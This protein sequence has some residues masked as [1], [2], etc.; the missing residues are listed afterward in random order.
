MHT[1]KEASRL[2]GLSTAAIKKRI[3]TGKLNA[4]KVKTPQG[5]ITWHIELPNLNT[6][7]QLVQQWVEDMKTGKEYPKPFSPKTIA[8]RLWYMGDLWKYSQEDPS[9]QALHQGTLKKALDALNTHDKCRFSTKEGILKAY[10]AF[11]SWL[12]L[13]GYAQEKHLAGL[14]NLKPK[15]F[16]PPRR[17]KLQAQQVHDLLQK[18]EHYPTTPYHK[19]RLKLLLKLILLSGLRIAE[20]LHLKLEDIRFDAQELH[21]LGK[22]NK[23]R[24]T[25]LPAP[26]AQHIQAWLR[27]YHKPSQTLFNNMTYNAARIALKRLSKHCQLEVT[28]HALRRTCATH[29]VNQGTPITMVAKLLGHSDIKTTQIY[30]EADALQ[31]IQ[32][33]SQLKQLL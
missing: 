16:I 1:I 18:L 8:S 14:N 26:L 19:A 23:R 32:Y 22:G 28:Y 30:V 33:V 6:Y 13:K 12:T 5:K 20:A 21:I 3:Y 15:R 25:V 10:R 24:I 27:D 4:Q 9:L 2:L 17:I 11:V 7:Q 31:A 29:W